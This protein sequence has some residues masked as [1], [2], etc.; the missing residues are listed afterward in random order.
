MINAKPGEPYEVV[1]VGAGPVGL[2]TALFL[3]D[4]GV[5]VLV[6]DRRD[7]LS[8]TPRAST[9]QRTLELFR[10][11]GLGASLDRMTWDGPRPLRTLVKDSAVGAVLHRAAP[12]EPYAR[13][14]DTCG[15]VGSRRVMTQY[16]VQ[17]IALDELRRRGGQVRF[18]VELVDATADAEAV[19]AR[20]TS[21]DTGRSGELVSRY[22][23]GA[24]GARSGVRK[25]FGMDMPAPRVAARLNTAFFRAEL[26]RLLPESSTYACFVRNEHVQCTLFAKGAAGDRWS[27]HIIAYPGKP[28]RATPLTPERTLGLLRAAIGDDTLPIDLT[29]CDAWEATFGT[30]SAFR[31]G[32]V[33]LA[34]DAAHLQSSAGGLGMNTGIQDGHN[35]AWKLAAVLRGRAEAA[36]LDSYEPERRIA[37]EASLALS[38]RMHDAYRAQQHPTELA[39]DYLRGMMFYRYTSAAVLAEDDTEPDVLDDRATPGRRLPHRWLTDGD[40]GLST[41]DLVGTDWTL[42]AGPRGTTWLEAGDDL[43]VRQVTTAMVDGDESVFTDLAGA[44]PDGALLV[45]PDGF[46]AW[47][48]P[49]LPEDPGGAVRRALRTLCGHG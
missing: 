23:V 29:A 31:R 18:G 39:A 7:S 47:R 10:S 12:P 28:D 43:R 3:A 40:A 35:L 19:R 26:G 45:R 16:E 48:S 8:V 1:V 2:S 46:V 25:L 6:V 21:V 49:R 34:G 24:D 33:F 38:Y 11:V 36:L 20:V 44:E 5:R 30:A 22:L 4:R 13:R 42:L 14:L 41:L 17:R 37:A 32:R 27:S 15:P 9:S